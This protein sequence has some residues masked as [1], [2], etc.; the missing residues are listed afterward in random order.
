MNRNNSI[1]W[2]FIASVLGSAITYFVNV[3]FIGFLTALALYFIYL[4]KKGVNLGYYILGYFLVTIILLVFLATVL[5]V[6][7]LVFGGLLG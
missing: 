7:L 2:G 3:P 1:V 4:K 5:G 6:S